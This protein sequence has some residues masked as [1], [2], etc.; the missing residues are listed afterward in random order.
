MYCYSLQLKW[1]E[2]FKFF[3][4]NSSKSLKNSQENEKKMIKCRYAKRAVNRKNGRR[5]RK[6]WWG[7]VVMEK[8]RKIIPLF[9]LMR[10]CQLREFLY[11]FDTVLKDI[12]CR[13]C[14]YKNRVMEGWNCICWVGSREEIM[15]LIESRMSRERWE[16]KKY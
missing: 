7:S 5:I 14:C 1:L 9:W 2:T 15:A 11:I 4:I 6:S 16:R 13:C 12:L 8:K 10:S 3:S